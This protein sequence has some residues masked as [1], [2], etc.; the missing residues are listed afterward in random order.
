M[1]RSLAILDVGEAALCEYLNMVVMAI[2]NGEA[3]LKTILKSMEEVLLRKRADYTD[4]VDTFSNFI[5]TGQMTGLG[6]EA[7]FKLLIATKIVRIME[8]TR[9][10]SREPQNEP[11]EDSILDLA[12]YSVLWLAWMLRERNTWASQQSVE[13]KENNDSNTDRDRPS[14][15]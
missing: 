15:R 11:L 14:G 10:G 5:K 4:G 3:E 1:A 6:T 12:N 13:W 7:S 8:L 2:S 9:D